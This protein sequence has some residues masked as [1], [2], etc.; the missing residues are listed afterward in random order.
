MRVYSKYLILLLLTCACS[1]VQSLS[2]QSEPVSELYILD[3]NLQVKNKIGNTP[4]EIDIKD[5]IGENDFLYL[6][7]KKEGYD[8]FR[9]VIPKNWDKG[10]LNVKLNPYEKY[11][12]DEL[13][14]KVLAETKELNI[15][16]IMVILD[17]QKEILKKNISLAQTK[18]VEL[19]KLDTPESVSSLIDA[20]IQY[21]SGNRE[22]ALGLYQK[23]LSLDPNNEQL[24]EVILKISG[25]KN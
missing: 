25:G 7:F 12:S 2:V 17:I 8:D 20:N 18:L 1:S 10:S 15:R 19:K 14:S 24:K 23:A 6:R 4:T 3:E 13:K 22:R 21:L 9:I 16:Q 11:A 5:L